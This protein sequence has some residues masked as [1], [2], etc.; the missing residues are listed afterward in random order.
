M[1]IPTPRTDAQQEDVPAHPHQISSS[2]SALPGR[3]ETV[4]NQVKSSRVME[5]RVPATRK[6]TTCGSGSGYTS[7][8]RAQYGGLTDAKSGIWQG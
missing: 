4:G 5:Q 8:T 2:I 7:R 3:C 1:T 6:V